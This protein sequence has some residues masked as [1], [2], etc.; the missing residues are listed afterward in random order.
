[1]RGGG[2]MDTPVEIP[3][4]HKG[5]I[6][7]WVALVAVVCIAIFAGW[8]GYMTPRGA[9]LLNA[10]RALLAD[11]NISGEEKRVGTIILENYEEYRANARNWSMVYFGCLFASAACAALAGVVIKLEFLLKTESV[12]KDV[13]ALLAMTSALLV[14]LS[15]AGGFHH[16]WFVNRL[17]AAKMEKVGYDFITADR[18]AELAR[19][20]VDI[21]AISYE[22]N[23]EIVAGDAKPNRGRE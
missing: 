19:F 16:R 20:S 23:A 10:M 7:A 4:Y 2:A 12:K 13:C 3:N 1:M 6:V 11:A 8:L 21:Q 14:T 17:A 9:G 5:K 18:K 22:R 15:T